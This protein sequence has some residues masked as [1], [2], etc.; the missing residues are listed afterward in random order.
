MAHRR[1]SSASTS[2][3]PRLR[4]SPPP[5]LRVECV[6]LNE[7]PGG[8]ER[9]RQ[10]PHC[11]AVGVGRSGTT[12]LHEVL[13]GHVGLPYGVKETDFFLRKYGNGID[14]YKSFFGHCAAGIPILEICPTYFSS[15]EARQR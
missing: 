10:M 5:E 7:R 3:L 11:I 6:K 8:K 14:W 4:L 12:W 9:R 1:Q 2:S 13:T 15:S